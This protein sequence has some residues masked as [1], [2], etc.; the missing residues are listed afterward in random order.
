MEYLFSSLEHGFDT[1]VADHNLPTFECKN[2]LSARQNPSIV[3]E[4][5]QTELDKGYVKGSFPQPPFNSYRVSPLEI[6]TH[7]Y[8]GKNRLIFDLSSPHKKADPSV[9]DLINKEQCSLSH[10]K[11]DDAIQLIQQF[12]VGSLM[13]KTDMT[14]AFK[15]IPIR[16]NQWHLFCFKWKTNYY[17]Y[18]RLPFGCRS[19]SKLFDT[20]SSAICWI[21]KNN[22]GIHNI[23]HLFIFKY[24]VSKLSV[25]M[26][27]YVFLYIINFCTYNSV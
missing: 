9:N 22:Y 23:L 15:Q 12:G 21:A 24:N 19:S 17:H 3:D 7:K 2:S 27:Q 6:A 14:D 25:P 16:P 1:L 20:L 5:L 10:V 13:C 18:V 26:I 4:L 11:I 8:S